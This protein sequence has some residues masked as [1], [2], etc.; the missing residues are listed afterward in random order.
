MQCRKMANETRATVRALACTAVLWLF[1]A[2]ASA[3]TVSVGS[4]RPYRDQNSLVTVGMKKAEVEAKAG[5]PD[6][7]EIIAL[8]AGEPPASVWNYVRKG[9]KGEIANLTFRGDELVKIELSPL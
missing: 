4:W 9:E 6:R 5:R 7:S 3:G 8:G 1:V 2:A